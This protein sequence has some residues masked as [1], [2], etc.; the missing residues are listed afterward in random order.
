ML[1]ATA[2]L[3]AGACSSPYSP[4]G[5]LAAA[6]GMQGRPVASL[7]N[8]EARLLTA[9]NRERAAIGVPPLVWDP[10]LAV[11]A[12]AYGPQLAALGRLQH[13]PRQGREGQGEN[14]WMGT[15]GA[16]SPEQMVGSWAS[17]KSLFRPG[18]FPDVSSNGNWADVA[19]YTQMVWHDTT[20]LGC[21][22][23][24]SAQWDILICRYAP[25]GNVVGQPVY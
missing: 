6:P 24:R 23:Q 21:A 9:H 13:S 3:L 7:D 22:V 10:A 8:L 18:I 2:V 25:Q 1:A 12:A 11:S 20:R 19:H 16:Y 15:R 14:L 5:T 4:P 17:E